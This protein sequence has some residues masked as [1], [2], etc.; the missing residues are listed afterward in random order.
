MRYPDH[1]PGRIVLFLV[2]VLLLAACGGRPLVLES[3]TIGS[4]LHADGEIKSGDLQFLFPSL[5]KGGSN[6]DLFNHLYFQGDTLCFSLLFNGDAEKAPVEISFIHPENGKDI[7]VE[8]VE[9]YKKRIYGFSLIGSLMEHHYSDL[10]RQSRP[11][12]DYCCR[13]IPFILRVRMKGPHGFVHTMKGN[14]V[15]RYRP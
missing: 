5:R 4:S 3:H 6:K 13:D 10:L 2:G 12:G 9:R 8:R 14:F 15:I 11:P 1:L 7:P